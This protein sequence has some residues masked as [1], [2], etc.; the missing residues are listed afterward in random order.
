MEKQSYR[1]QVG[2]YLRL[3]WFKLALLGMLVFVF[4]RKDLS[5]QFNINS[6]NRIE[7][8]APS[9]SEGAPA[10]AGATKKDPLLTQKK[11]RSSA[12]TSPASSYSS[13]IEL[14]ILGSAS[15]EESARAELATID[16]ATREKYLK[17]FGHV[18]VSESKKYGIPAS[19]ILANAVL[20]SSYGQRDLARRGNNHFGIPCT[21][22]WRGESSTYNDACYR[23]YENAWSSFRDHSLYLTSGRFAQLRQLLAADDYRAWANGLEELRYSDVYDKLAE[24]L[25]AIVEAASLQGLD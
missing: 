4:L 1:S 19:I 11:G 3:N 7:Q 10:E 14:P 17:R 12:M 23:H 21:S 13:G 18:A 5:F 8:P 16:A 24:R 20:H 25:I 15:P 6:P 2:S 22:Q 9:E